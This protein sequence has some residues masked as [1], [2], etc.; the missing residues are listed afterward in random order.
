MERASGGEAGLWPLVWEVG[1]HVYL[2]GAD[3]QAVSPLR[4][5][6]AILAVEASAQIHSEAQGAKE[7]SLKTFTGSYE[8]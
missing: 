5:C 1:V 6:P 7:Y 2:Q 3:R 4:M 8:E